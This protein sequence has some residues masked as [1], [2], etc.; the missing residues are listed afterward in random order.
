MKVIIS[1]SLGKAQLQK[2]IG[3]AIGDQAV[4][5][6]NADAAIAELPTADALIC[7]DPFIS[8]KVAEAIR[9][10]SKLRWVQL[11]TAGYDQIK[12]H[13]VPPHVTVC[14]AGTAYAPGVATHAV[15]L[16]L[17]LQRQL[18]TALANQGQRAWE[19]DFTTR[20]TT[21][22]GS[23][24]AVIGF[25]PIGRE[26]GR[27]LRALGAKVIAVTR[28][29]LPQQE[30]DEVAPVSELRS[31]LERA[32]AII[33]AA[34]LDE[35]TRYLIAE[36]EFAACKKN[37]LLINISRGGIVEPLAL[38]TALRTGAIAGAGLDVTDPE[39]LPSDHSLWDAPNLIITPHCAGASGP[40]AGER[41]ADLVGDNLGRFLR[42]APL[43]HVLA[44]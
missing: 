25:G 5:V 18:P 38:E 12:Q 40:I 35:A 13:G 22:G 15:A 28:R 7:R 11:L 42:G 10:A 4:W 32:D 23:T 39:P 43:L 20:V 33:I 16:L 30:A 37:A 44:L 6:D 34:P 24:V 17:A 1:A 41:L 3:E 29:G 8:A 19:R 27:L 9:Q 26:I 14:N 2:R 21:P 36:R 31:V